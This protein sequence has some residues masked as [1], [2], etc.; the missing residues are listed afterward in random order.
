MTDLNKINMT[1]EQQSDLPLGSIASFDNSKFFF[2]YFEIKMNF[3]T[4]LKLFHVHY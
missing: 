2:N 3:Q 1:P 4:L